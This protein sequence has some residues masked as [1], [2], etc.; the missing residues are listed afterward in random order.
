MKRL[1]SMAYT[2]NN[3]NFGSEKDCK[4]RPSIDKDGDSYYSF[5]NKAL[6]TD[7]YLSNLSYPESL[8]LDYYGENYENSIL[9]ECYL[10]DDRKDK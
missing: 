4:M 5:K 3:S 10:E 7:S 1:D 6:N 8:G 2:I 9:S